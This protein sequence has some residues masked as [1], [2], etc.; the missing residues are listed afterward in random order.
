MQAELSVGPISLGAGTRVAVILPTLNEEDGLRRTV[1][2]IPVDLLA[3]C[4]F[5]V[6]LIVVDGG[7]TDSTRQ[8]ADSLGCVVLRQTGHGKGGATRDGL[9]YAR[10]QGCTYAVVMD[11]D[12]T[13]PGSGVGPILSL[14]QAGSDF[15]IGVRR[16]EYNPLGIVRNLVHRIGDGFL[17][18][19]AARMSRAPILDLTS[20]L[21][22]LRT[23]LLP[24][25]ALEST[26]FEIEAEAFLKAFRFGAKVSQIPIAYRKRVGVAKLHAARDGWRIGLGIIRYARAKPPAPLPA[27]GFV[28]NTVADLQ[29]ICYAAKAQRLVVFAHP[30]R[31][32]EA[33]ELARSLQAAQVGVQVEI[34]TVHPVG[35]TWVGPPSPLP[36]ERAAGG[37]GEVPIV[38][39]LPSSHAAGEP[40][41]VAVVGLPRTRR[42]VY[43][44]PIDPSTGPSDGSL[45]A[46]SG[47]LVW[48]GPSGRRLRTMK[49]LT[50]TM[51]PSERGRELTLM[52][53]N[54]GSRPMSVFDHPEA[55][56][57]RGAGEAAAPA[58]R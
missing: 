32:P 43:L 34:S 39:Y 10:A 40:L 38:V 50:S 29:A 42:W 8:V 4:G 22:G 56:P 48:E 3:N 20:G 23:E 44:P 27:A 41:P 11:A 47:G 16:P 14:L 17:T 45:F 6:S 55:S 31:Q 57:S 2:D 37:P 24:R 18:I 49:I 46:R 15:V 12:Y 58:D 53:A 52:S 19:L 21:W 54:V 30:A 26:G 13:Y 9:E 51:N 28:G 5:D 1:E 33:R 25:L 36:L 35:H 7:S